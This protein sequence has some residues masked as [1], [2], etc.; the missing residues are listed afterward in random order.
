MES[1]KQMSVNRKWMLCSVA[2][3]VG[4]FFLVFCMD[5]GRRQ[6]LLLQSVETLERRPASGS[7]A[8]AAGGA[9]SRDVGVGEGPF[10]N[11]SPSGASLAAPPTAL[12]PGGG[13]LVEPQSMF[14]LFPQQPQDQPLVMEAPKSPPPINQA[15]PQPSTAPAPASALEDVATTA[16]PPSGA[17]PPQSAESLL[18]VPSMG[19]DQEAAEEEK[20]NIFEGKW[21]YDAE[22][23][24]LYRATQCPFLSD[25]VNCQKNGRPDSNYEHW[26]W[27]PSGCDIPRST[28]GRSMLERLRGKRVVIVGDSLNRN[29]WESLSCLLY[30]SVRPSRAVVKAHGADYKV[31]QALDYNC[32]VEFFWSPFLVRLEVLSSGKKVIRL[33]KLPPSARR[34]QN[35]DVMVFNTGHWWTHSGKMRSWDLYQRGG[36]LVED[37]DVNLAF[38]TALRTWSRW[39]DKKVDPAKTRVFFRSIS[40]EHKPENLHWCFNQ[41]H[42]ITNE[43]YIQWFPRSMVEA[44]EKAVANTRTPVDYLN[45]TRLSEFRREAHTSVYTVRQMKLLTEEQRRQPKRFA[46]CSHWCLP[47][48]PDTWNVLLYASILNS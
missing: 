44:V 4:F 37:M 12:Q 21:V 31:F 14:E 39:V 18:L 26:R 22:A 23:Y 33:D 36:E 46:D 47:G 13:E 1:A 5:Q 25:Q 6:G 17:L 11:H 29:Q 40:P 30:S 32:T 27:Q 20:C 2:S 15:S 43:T 41:T 10:L 3:F 48:L 9:V 34:W 16:L 7:L 42:P 19:S 38:Q 8:M 24:P 35:A 45:I 28:D